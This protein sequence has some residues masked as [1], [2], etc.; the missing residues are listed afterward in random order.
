MKNIRTTL[1]VGLW[2]QLFMRKQWLVNIRCMRIVFGKR[3]EFVF[4]LPY[5]TLVD[6][7]I[8]A[9]HTY[10]HPGIHKTH[11]LLD[12]KY[13]LHYLEQD[14]TQ[15]YLY[16]KLKGRITEIVTS[17]QVCQSVGGRKS[18]QPEQLNPTLY[19]STFLVQLP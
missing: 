1:W 2:G 15:K 6:R 4:L 8:V 14:H 10:A 19:L 3:G 16:N 13:N 12:C 11:Q 9:T 18:L 17:C 7:V 5:W